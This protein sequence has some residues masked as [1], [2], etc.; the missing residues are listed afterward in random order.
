MRTAIWNGSTAD[1]AGGKSPLLGALH[2]QQ[3]RHAKTHFMLRGT[4]DAP[5]SSSPVLCFDTPIKFSH[6]IGSFK[7]KSS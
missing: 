3:L 1:I 2:G 5:S 6:G 7:N 4:I